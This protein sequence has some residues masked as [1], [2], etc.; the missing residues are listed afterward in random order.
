MFSA[1]HEGNSAT[2]RS[3]KVN[4]AENLFAVIRVNNAPQ[5]WLTL[6]A[7]CKA[8]QCR[9]TRDFRE[10]IL[11]RPFHIALAIFFYFYT[12]SS[13]NTWTKFHETHLVVALKSRNGIRLKLFP[14]PFPMILLTSIFI[15]FHNFQNQQKVSPHQIFTLVNESRIASGGDNEIDSELQVG[16]RRLRQ[17]ENFAG[18]DAGSRDSEIK[19]RKKKLWL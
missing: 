10:N 1:K 4:K 19:W 13:P 15:Q 14:S 17:C 8:L 2:A 3:D 11:R 9:D 16:E 18:T 5:P 6:T 7:T 12:F